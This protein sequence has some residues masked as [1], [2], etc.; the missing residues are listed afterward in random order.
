MQIE[1]LVVLVTCVLPYFSTLVEYLVPMEL[2]LVSRIHWISNVDLRVR[3][4]LELSLCL[5]ITLD[6][7]SVDR[8]GDDGHS[9]ISLRLK[10]GLIVCVGLMCCQ[11][12]HE[13]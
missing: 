13:L 6:L 1:V 11:L 5:H 12:M 10:F 3:H 2:S 8:G 4:G 7:G 9:R